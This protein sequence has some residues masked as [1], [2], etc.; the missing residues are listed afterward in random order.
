LKHLIIFI[1]LTQ[2]FFARELNWGY[3]LKGKAKYE[4]ELQAASERAKLSQTLIESV[5][6]T[7]NAKWNPNKV[8]S[9]SCVGLM[10]VKKGSKNPRKNLISGSLILKNHTNRCN[11]DVMIGLTSYHRGYTGMKRYYKRN[12]KHSEYAVTVMKFYFEI[13]LKSK[14]KTLNKLMKDLK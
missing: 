5:V 8:N 3:Y 2:P 12:D 4:K 7:E 9:D 10:Q 13:K 6:C 1:L 11:G 14:L